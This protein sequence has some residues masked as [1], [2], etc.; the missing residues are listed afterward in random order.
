MHFKFLAIQL[1]SLA[2]YTMGF[3][4]PPIVSPLQRSP[5]SYRFEQPSQLLY[6]PNSDISLKNPSLG[7][8]VRHYV[9]SRHAKLGSKLLA[10]RQSGDSLDSGGNSN[11]NVTS[12]SGL[13]DHADFQ[14][15]DECYDL[16]ETDEVVETALLQDSDS[17]EN[18][19]SPPSIEVQTQH[20]KP[21]STSKARQLL[22]L[23]WNIRSAT[24]DCDL[25][26]ILSCSVPCDVCRGEGKILCKFCDGRGY[27]EFGI[28]EEGTIGDRLVQNNGGFTSCECPVCDDNGNQVCQK[29]NGSGWIAP[30]RLSENGGDNL[31]NLQP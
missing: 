8:N 6:P 2:F 23:Q 12:L 30:W 20:G 15:V 9:P 16:C 18:R 27:I 7:K 14:L 5:P 28:Q 31:E 21:K 10:A 29:C 19:V 25:E 13:L 1:L 11:G 17:D 3:E 24:E 26:D 22:D 4:F